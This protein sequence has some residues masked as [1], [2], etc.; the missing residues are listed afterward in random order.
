V[1][2]VGVDLAAE[3]EGTAIACLEWSPGHA[4][5]RGLLLGAEDRQILEVVKRADKAG[6]DCPLGWP[7]PFI[8]F[9]S[10]HQHGNVAVP[11]ELAGRDWRRRLAY[12]CTDVAVHELTGRWPLS[13]AADRIGHTAMRAAGLLARLAADGQP[14]DRAGAGVVVEVYPAAS[15]QRWG[16]PSRGYKR[17]ANL[18]VLNDLVDRLT[19]AAPWLDLDAAKALYRSSDHAID[20]I[21]AALTA[22]AAAQG[23]VTMPTAEQLEPARI[24]GW[25]AVPKSSI[26]SLNG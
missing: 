7:A 12:R 4:R 22:R 9:V 16:L 24:E 1:L 6:I 26:S 23:L 10:A 15:L 19:K 11:A 18:G 5:L 17:K 13:V 21:V 25:I 14:V 2:T 3:S 8:E 20:A